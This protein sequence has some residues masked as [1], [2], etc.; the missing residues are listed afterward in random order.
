MKQQDNRD[1]D[2]E[3]D[4]L[5][6]Q[7]EVGACVGI[8]KR[9]N[10]LLYFLAFAFIVVL[11]AIIS[12]QFFGGSGSLRKEAKGINY[13]MVEV[14]A[15]RGD[16]LTANGSVFSSSV[17]K[18]KV[19]MDLRTSQLSDKNFN[20]NLKALADSLSTLFKDASPST[21][22]E[23]LKRW[24]KEEHGNKLISPSGVLLDFNEL[25]RLKKFPILSGHPNNGGAKEQH[26][27]ERKNYYGSLA[28]RTIGRIATANAKGY[29]LEKSFENI[30]KG[31]D[32]KNFHRKISG[33]FWMPIDSGDDVEPVDGLDLATTID[34]NVQDVA[35]TSLRNTI[36]IYQA[37][38]G[39]AVVMEVSTGE[40]KAMVNLGRNRKNEIIE[41]YNHAIGENIEPGSTFKLLPLMILLDNTDMTLSTPI[42]TKKGRDTINRVTVNDSERGGNGVIPLKTAMSKSSNIAFARA[43]D[44]YFRHSPEEYINHIHATGITKEFKFQLEG[45]TTPFVKSSTQK[46]WSS[47]DLVTMSYG[48]ATRFNALRILMLYNAVANDGKLITPIVVKQTQRNGK[49][50]D[51]YSSEVL[52]SSICSPSTL[53]KVREALEDV[54]FDGTV[55]R[56]FQGENY[57]VAGKTGTSRQVGP[58]GKYQSDGGV[59]YLASFVGYFPA[60]DPKYSCIVQLKTFK[61]DGIAR[62]Y[63]GASLAAPIFKDI[64]H[65]MSTVSDWG[66][67][68]RKYASEK[69]LELANRREAD[70]IRENRAAPKRSSLANEA[71]TGNYRDFTQ[72]PIRVIGGGNIN[73]LKREFDLEDYTLD[74]PEAATDKPR[75]D[76]KMP[77]VIGLGLSDAIE[78]LE[79]KGMSVTVIG[80]GRVIRQSIPEGTTIYRGSKVEL[81]LSI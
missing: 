75:K 66:H 58:N 68:A 7:E 45:E 72:T 40:V 55:R 6:E 74:I 52:N 77:R 9:A 18:Y 46:S 71:E 24:R 63:Y 47:S 49:T 64:S 29:G 57:V 69:E 43:V 42:D 2:L 16:I 34:A 39:T 19:F 65:Y 21:Y 30:L 25:T 36:D 80:K 32:G 27:Y 20:N 4:K 17:K 33:T 59:Y 37:I 73:Y 15:R 11:Y 76:G 41:D 22:R 38:W 28:Q 13:K 67:R 3:I 14:P 50:V 53:K 48:Y 31:V 10:Y 54:M 60:N 5:K 1:I 56:V 81:H 23:R 62:T 78:K 12:L 61:P 79:S 70:A 51:S 35:E 8:S 26:V 44:K